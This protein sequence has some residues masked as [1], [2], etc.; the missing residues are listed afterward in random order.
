MA[1]YDPS[2]SVSFDAD[3]HET[4]SSWTPAVTAGEISDGMQV[5]CSV[6]T[7]M[8]ACKCTNSDG[9]LS[10]SITRAKHGALHDHAWPCEHR[11]C[12]M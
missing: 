1:G 9:L 10:W 12:A 7:R 4:D 3:L 6:C 11:R 2:A 5:R 8:H